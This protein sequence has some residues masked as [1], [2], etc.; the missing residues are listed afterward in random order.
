MRTFAERKAALD[1]LGWTVTV[2]REW[3]GRP[4]EGR[5]EHDLELFSGVKLPL[6]ARDWCR[7][8]M[9]HQSSPLALQRGTDE[10]GNVLYEPSEELGWD[11][12][13][14]AAQHRIRGWFHGG[15]GAPVAEV[16]E[17]GDLL[18]GHWGDDPDQNA[19]A[20]RTPEQLAEAVE[21][22]ILCRDDMP[23]GTFMS[24]L[25]KIALIYHLVR[26]HYTPEVPE[27]PHERYPDIEAAFH[28]VGHM[29]WALGV[30]ELFGFTGDGD[31]QHSATL[32]MMVA[33]FLPAIRTIHREISQLVPDP[34]EGWALIDR[35]AGDGEIAENGNGLCVFATRADCEHLIRMWE[36]TQ[37]EHEDE[38][39]TPRKLRDKP[40]RERIGI[41]PVRISAEA[42]IEF[43][44]DGVQP[45][46]R[47]VIKPERPP[48]W[49]KEPM[50]SPRALFLQWV[51]TR[52]WRDQ[53][54]F[55]DEYEAAY[56]A[57]LDAAAFFGGHRP[58]GE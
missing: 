51:E 53:D 10:E 44:D 50:E 22:Y 25:G 42:G 3:R 18:R 56:Q 46:T 4:D 12:A 30:R 17:F 23:E 16:V 13:L 40:V 39:C 19:F 29:S 58:G 14:E 57:W 11:R 6:T 7:L 5:E 9:D 15:G 37:E 47:P 21:A 27:A 26:E 36:Q 55:P 24:A 52:A 49:L 54:R 31:T 20:D 34:V 33:R 48:P 45:R 28:T 38:V 35:N 2:Q 41:R 32:T 1:R 43:L 8:C